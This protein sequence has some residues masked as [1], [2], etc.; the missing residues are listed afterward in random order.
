M[1]YTPVEERSQAEVEAAISKN[2]EM[3]LSQAVLSAAL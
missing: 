3:D 2:E 1:E